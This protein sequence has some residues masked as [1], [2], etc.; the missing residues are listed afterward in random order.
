MMPGERNWLVHRGDPQL[1]AARAAALT[2][3]RLAHAYRDPTVVEERRHAVGNIRREWV[4]DEGSKTA[5]GPSSVI[6]YA[7]L[8]AKH[9]ALEPGSTSGENASSSSWRTDEVDLEHSASVGHRRRDSRGVDERP[10]RAERADFIGEPRHCDGIGDVAR[11][12]DSAFDPRVFE[13]DRD[14]TFSLI[15]ESLDAR[16][17]HAARRASD[18]NDAHEHAPASTRRDYRPAQ[19]AGPSLS[20]P[21]VGGYRVSPAALRDSPTSRYTRA[22]IPLVGRSDQRDPRL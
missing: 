4:L 20:G 1:T 10:E 7:E 8:D 18:D 16:A 12:A 2:T 9:R 11:E 17:A 5:S 22:C 19:R 14:E 13:V 21:F 15:A 3:P 6:W